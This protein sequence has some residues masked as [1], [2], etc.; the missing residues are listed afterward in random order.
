MMPVIRP[1]MFIEVNHEVVI[2]AATP[3]VRH[4]ALH[5]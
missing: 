2:T 4:I 5:L 1:R 3:A